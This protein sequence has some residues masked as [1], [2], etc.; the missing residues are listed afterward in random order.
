MGWSNQLKNPL[1]QLH[2]VAYSV[3]AADWSGGRWKGKAGVSN[4]LV[5]SQTGMPLFETT[6]ICL[7][8]SSSLVNLPRRVWFGDKLHRGD[9]GQKEVPNH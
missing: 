4:L 2:E 5:T 3:Q 8:C 9:F 1:R 6:H 7:T